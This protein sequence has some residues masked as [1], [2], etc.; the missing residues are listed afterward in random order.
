MT[1]NHTYEKAIQN[2]GSNY[3][4]SFLNDLNTEGLT[5]IVQGIKYFP[6]SKTRNLMETRFLA[7]SFYSLSKNHQS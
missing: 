2:T 5:S 4:Q 3:R 1:N 6:L 7:I